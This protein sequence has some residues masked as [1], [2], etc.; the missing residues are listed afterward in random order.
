MSLFH[1]DTD[2]PDSS[3]NGNHGTPQNGP[4]ISHIPILGGGAGGFG[5]INDLAVG[6]I[7]NCLS[8]TFSVQFWAKPTTTHEVDGPFRNGTSGISAQRYV[9]EARHVGAVEAAGSGALT[10]IHRA[11]DLPAKS[12]PPTPAIG[13]ATAPASPFWLGNSVEI[14]KPPLSKIA[15]ADPLAPSEGTLPARQARGSRYRSFQIASNTG[16]ILAWNGGSLTITQTLSYTLRSQSC[17]SG[18]VASDAANSCIFLRSDFAV[19]RAR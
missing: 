18:I 13:S 16:S 4:T 12:C 17:F 1:M 5:G 6:G 8:N 15:R 11:D 2:R 3:G 19:D 9:F 7:L 10:R 14:S